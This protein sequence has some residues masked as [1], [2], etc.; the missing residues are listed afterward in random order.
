MSGEG[1]HRTKARLHAS[2]CPGA[3]IN[4]FCQQVLSIILVSNFCCQQHLVLSLV[5]VSFLFF[6]DTPSI[7]LVCAGERQSKLVIQADSFCL[8][9]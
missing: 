8:Q 5:S 3:H 9:E 2:L 4:S 7:L 6:F 1:R